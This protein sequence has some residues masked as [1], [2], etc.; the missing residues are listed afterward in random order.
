[1][2]IIKKVGMIFWTAL[3]FFCLCAFSAAQQRPNAEFVL[4]DVELPLDSES[5][6]KIEQTVRRH[7]RFA[8]DEKN[9]SATTIGF[10]FA[11]PK[12][13]EALAETTRF[14]D[15][16]NLAK[17]I[18]DK[19][20]DTLPTPNVVT[21]ALL[22]DSLAGNILLPVFACD[23]LAAERET[24]F[25][26]AGDDNREAYR[27]FFTKKGHEPILEAMLAPDAPL[28]EAQTDA[29]TEWLSESALAEARS[30]GRIFLD[31]P[32]PY[33][34]PQGRGRFAAEELRRIGL[35]DFLLDDADHLVSLPA[36][37]LRPAETVV[38]RLPVNDAPRC[39]LVD[40]IG[41]ISAKQISAVI[42]KIRAAV[43]QGYERIV[44]RIDSPGGSLTDALRL[45]SFLA[46]DLDSGRVETVAWI[47]NRALGDAF[48]AV[49]GSRLI[50]CAPK[51]RIAGGG[52][53][54][55]TPEEMAAA[56]RTLL[57]QKHSRR[58]ANFPLHLI[59]DA[60]SPLTGEEALAAG[61]IDATADTFDRLCAKLQITEPPTPPT[62]S[63]VE[64]LLRALADPKWS[65]I[66]LIVA[67]LALGGEMHTPGF[68]GFGLVSLFAFLLFF[69][70]R[71]LGGTADGLEVIL[72]LFGLLCLLTE[73]FVLP[74]FGFCG[75]VGIVMVLTAVLL[76]G[77]TFV[78]PRNPCQWLIFRQSL[79]YLIIAG[80]GLFLVGALGFARLEK[81]CRPTDG[82]KIAR[83]EKRVDYAPLVGR[84]GV[85]AT[86]L[87]PAGKA[88]FDGESF[89][90]ISDGEWIDTERT[91]IVTQAVGSR[92]VVRKKQS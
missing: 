83:S 34:F 12:N 60:A 30:T 32:K 79:V 52:V 4:I 87:C 24:R 71:F 64:F 2:T 10:R 28:F 37:L 8:A 45:M 53:G 92:I 5:S 70:G 89:D 9:R 61:R 17:F 56:Q 41:P 25:G 29:G 40:L 72:F 31:T 68:G 38:S 18:F 86:P 11:V 13:R 36:Q 15:A 81:R 7:F 66:L 58:A 74:G 63:N 78:W 54:R 48:L 14:G 50:V 91:I 90:V 22:P 75:I 1:M 43:D 42:Q 39:A 59:T 33:E 21:V 51:A 6:E 76:A 20:F 23:E 49:C 88:R 16:Y 84:V 57:A 3:A 46:D 73:F 85:T 55:F 19:K 35:I 67:F 62:L 47:P 77:Q 27:K 44:L 26:P 82:E 80:F 69:W 65:A